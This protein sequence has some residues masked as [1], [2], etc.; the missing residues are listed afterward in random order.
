MEFDIEKRENPNS[1]SYSSTELG[2]AYEFAKKI[3]KEFGDSIK[4][5]ILFGSSARRK[6]VSKQ[7][8]VDVLIVFDDVTM[9]LT[10]EIVTA[11]RVIIEKTV[12]QTSTRLHITSVKLTTFWEYVRAGDPI[13]MNILRDGVAILDAGFF[14]PL[15]AL[16]ARGRI[17][18]TE[19]AVWTYFGRAPRAVFNSKW[20]V[21]QAAL[22]LY[23]AV[24][25][26][27]HAALMKDGVLPP[28]PDH[29]ADVLDET[30]VRSG[31]IEKKYSDIM[32]KFYDLQKKIMYRQI[33]EVSGKDWDQY[34]KDAQAFV[35]RIDGFIRK[36]KEK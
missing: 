20:H 26:A 33:R 36:N 27:A 28:S 7:S 23:W 24:I 32:R 22:D 35:A 14:D 3:H 34:L 4:A 12:A 1:R 11:Y 19:E 9:T 30:L 13:G 31:R 10:R 17:R 25:D 8:D 21:M 16:L 5:L 6:N 2:L 29:V 15:R 18:P